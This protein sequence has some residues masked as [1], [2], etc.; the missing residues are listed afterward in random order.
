MKKPLSVL[1]LLGASLS[2]IPL[3]QAQPG[4]GG[5]PGMGP[6]PGGGPGMGPGPRRGPG[7]GG[8]GPYRGPG[9]GFGPYA[10]PYPGPYCGPPPPWRYVPRSTS[11]LPTEYERL[12]NL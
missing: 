11:D 2:M 9:P 5:G 6:G 8:P 3:S 1:I 7:P 12:H 10:Y 4:P